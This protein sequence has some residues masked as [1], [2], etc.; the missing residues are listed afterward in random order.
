MGTRYEALIYPG[1][2]V[3]GRGIDLVTVTDDENTLEWFPMP[4]VDEWEIDD[5]PEALA[6]IDYIAIGSFQWKEDLGG[7]FPGWEVEVGDYGITTQDGQDVTHPCGCPDDV[8][9][10]WLTNGG[11]AQSVAQRRRTE[12]GCHEFQDKPRLIGLPGVRAGRGAM[13]HSS[14]IRLFRQPDSVEAEQ[15]HYAHVTAL[16]QAG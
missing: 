3:S 16:P 9:V 12:W 13:G 4:G 1:G 8:E 15:L 2:G 11:S 10:R 5:V 7:G 14:V 6:S